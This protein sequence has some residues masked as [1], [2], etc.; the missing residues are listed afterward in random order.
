M[1]TDKSFWFDKKVLVTG[2]TGFKGSWLV[3]WLQSMGAK[4]IGISLDPPTSPSLYNKAKVSKGIV[5]IR[6][7]ICNATKIRNIFQEHN[8]EIV[9]H[10]AAQPLVRYSYQHPTETYKTNVMGT[11][12]I[13]EGVR[14]VNSVRS[15]VLVTTD[16]CY[17]NKEWVWGYREI[18]PL[19]GHDPYSSSKAAMELLASSYRD[20]YFSKDEYSTHKVALATVR[21]G[22][23]I[24]GG[25]WAKDRLI[26]DI[27][28]AFE[29]KNKIIIRNPDSIRP[30]QHVLDPLSGYIKLA[31]LL[32]K[33]GCKYAQAWNFSPRDADVYSVKQIVEKMSK[34][35]E[36]SSSYK[37]SS[38]EYQVHEANYLK[39]DCSKA[40]KE[41]H[42]ASRWSLDVSISKVIEWHKSKEDGISYRDACLGQIKEFNQCNVKR[43]G[44]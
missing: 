44:K 23:V 35:W 11:L 15:I 16:K 7:D 30:W 36:S 8:P 34:Y 41:L 37:V 3:I 6:Q 40:E 25:D 18:D 33:D 14:S 42:W 4:I 29:G 28:N 32:Y 12:N 9:F 39:L 21:A 5:D 2:H 20:S 13:L 17:Q 24:G 10:L 1:V 43:P 22:N 19:G 27:V 26:P 31:E 38:D